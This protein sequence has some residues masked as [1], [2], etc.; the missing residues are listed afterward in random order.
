[1][2]DVKSDHQEKR[3]LMA[4]ALAARANSYCPYSG[5][6]VGAALLTAAGHIYCGCNIENAGY[7][8]TLCAERAAM[9]QAVSAGERQFVMLAVAGGPVGKAP[10]TCFWPCGVCRQWLAEF[11]GPD[12]PVLCGV[13]ESDFREVALSDLLPYAFSPATLT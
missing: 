8:P 12:F 5:Y 2:N 1:M 7:S 10:E 6:S 9:A 4:R 11:C 13:S 3:E